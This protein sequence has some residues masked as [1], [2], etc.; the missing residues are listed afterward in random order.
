MAASAIV[1]H[2]GASI[3]NR[4]DLSVIAPCVPANNRDELIPINASGRPQVWKNNPKA[5]A[6]C[7]EKDLQLLSENFP[8]V[9]EA[10]FEVAATSLIWVNDS[11]C[12]A[13]MVRCDS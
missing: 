4:G 5:S 7:I 11:T 6:S 13:A 2:E 3:Q 12:S 8:N 10:K 9:L 1:G